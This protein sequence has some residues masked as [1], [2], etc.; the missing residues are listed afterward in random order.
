MHNSQLV[1]VFDSA[2]NLLEELAGFGFL[3]FLLLDDVVEQLAAA[4][5]LHDEKEL[6]RRLNNFKQLDDVRVPDQ[7]EN[8]NLSRHSLYICIARDLTLLKNLNSHLK[9]KR[10]IMFEFLLRI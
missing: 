7:L 4:D 8:V 10:I 1:Q 3:E 2:D 5:K 6:F 9:G